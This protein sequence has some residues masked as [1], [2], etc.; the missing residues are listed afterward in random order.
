[1]GKGWGFAC[2]LRDRGIPEIIRASFS[3]IFSFFL[4]PFILNCELADVQIP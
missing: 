2:C 3:P 1:M 4:N